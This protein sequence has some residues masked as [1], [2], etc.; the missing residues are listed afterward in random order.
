MQMVNQKKGLSLRIYAFFNRAKPRERLH[1]DDV[2][3][4]V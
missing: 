2:F 1:V 4:T 3:I